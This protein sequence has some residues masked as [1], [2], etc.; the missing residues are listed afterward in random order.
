M[1]KKTTRSTAAKRAGG[2]AKGQE[3]PEFNYTYK[4][5]AF[6]NEYLVDLNATQAAIRA[7][8]SKETANEIGCQ[9]LAKVSIRQAIQKAMDLRAKRTEITADRV[10]AELGK[11]S[12]VDIRNLVT[13]GGHMRDLQDL[14]DDT[15]ASIQSVEL[16]TRQTG[17][18]DE[19]GRKIVENVHKIRLVD[20][21]GSLDT[22]AKHLKLLT[23]K[24][25][26]SG[27]N[28]GPI[29]TKEVGTRELARRIAFVLTKG[30]K[31]TK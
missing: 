11:I 14:D 2:K 13:A 8:Y 19:N 28:G 17:E 22:L 9:N 24:V 29:E 25:E 5:Q 26:H 30:A 18:E 10:I 20:K 12:F 3:L 4:Q 16:V 7:G 31:K 15:A 21:K 6:I 27:P 23:D 1:T